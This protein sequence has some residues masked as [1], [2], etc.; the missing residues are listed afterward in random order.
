MARVTA[1]RLR[2][3]FDDADWPMV[4]EAV[5]DHAERRSSDP[6]V[7]A[8]VRAIPRGE[9]GRVEDV[10]GAVPTSDRA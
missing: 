2:D 7:V 5:V 6:D 3:V 1:E 10:L 4:K 8:A 9:Y